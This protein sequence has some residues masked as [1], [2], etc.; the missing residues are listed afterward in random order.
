[1]SLKNVKSLYNEV[2][3]IENIQKRQRLTEVEKF[4]LLMLY[5]ELILSHRTFSIEKKLNERLWKSVFYSN[6]ELEKKSQDSNKLMP[7]IK[8]AK[9]FYSVQISQFL[10]EFNNLVVDYYDFQKFDIIEYGLKKYL[11]LIKKDYLYT[12]KDEEILENDL[13]EILNLTT[14]SQLCL[15]DSARYEALNLKTDIDD[16]FNEAIQ[17]YKQS[18]I[19]KPGNGRAYC[20]LGIIAR[21][22]N[23]TFNVIYFYALSVS[24]IQRN[25]NALSNLKIIYSSV[26]S[27]ARLIQANE[28]SKLDNIF[29]LTICV[30]KTL[31]YTTD[32][33]INDVWDVTE[34]LRLLIQKKIFPKEENNK[35]Y[36]STQ[37]DMMDGDLD[38]KDISNLNKICFLIIFGFVELERKFVDKEF[39]NSKHRIR[40]LQVVALTFLIDIANL[41][42]V[43]INADISD[44]V[45]TN[46]NIFKNLNKFKVFEPLSNVLTWFGLNLPMLILY[47]NL[48]GELGLKHKGLESKLNDLLNNLALALNSIASITD[49]DGSLEFLNTDFELLLTDIYKDYFK[50]LEYESILN[51]FKDVARGSNL[52]ILPKF[53][54][55]GSDLISAGEKIEVFM[56]RVAGFGKT[57]SLENMD[58][59][60]FVFDYE[61]SKFELWTKER[62]RNEG[63]KKLMKVLATQLLTDQVKNLEMQVTSLP[64]SKPILILHHD[65]FIKHLRKVKKWLGFQS[66][67]IVLTLEVIETLDFLKKGVEKVNAQ[68]RETIR[69]LEQKL[70]YKNQSIKT[71]KPNEKYDFDFESNFI[72]STTLQDK[73]IETK[74]NNDCKVPKEFQY[75]ELRSNN[76]SSHIKRTIIN[77]SKLDGSIKKNTQFIKKL[78]TNLNSENLPNLIQD[79]NSLKLEKY[80]E[81]IVIALVEASSKLTKHSEF[82]AL[83]HVASLLHQRFDSFHQPFLDAILSKITPPPK[84]SELKILTPEQR[85]RDERDRLQRQKGHL[86]VLTDMY[87]L[88]VFNDNLPHKYEKKDVMLIGALKDIFEKDLLLLNITIAVTFVKTFSI[89]FFPSTLTEKTTAEEVKL[90][91]GSDESLKSDKQG[92]HLSRYLDTKILNEIQEI[93][94]NYLRNAST[95]LVKEHHRIRQ[96]EKTNNE[97]FIAKGEV[98]EERQ[99][100]YEKALKSFEKV[101]GY[102]QTLAEF[103]GETL[104]ELKIEQEVTRMGV[105][106]GIS[107]DGSREREEKDFKDVLWEDDDTRAFYEDIIDLKTFV[108]SIFFSEKLKSGAK[109]DPNKASE[110]GDDKGVTEELENGTL[111]GVELAE[112]EKDSLPNNP[113][114]VEEEIEVEDIDIENELEEMKDDKKAAPVGVENIFTRIPVSMNRQQIDDIA[115]EFCDYNTKNARKRLVKVLLSSPRQRLDVLPY[116]SRLICT[117][118]IYFPEIGT[119]VLDSLQ[120]EFHFHVKK[121]D[122]H[123][124]E[125]RVKNIR[126]IAELTKFRVTPVHVIFHCIKVLLDSFVSHNI[127]TLCNLLETCGRFLF[128]SAETNLRISNYLDLM[129]KKKNIQNL[130]NRQCLMIENAYYHCN[131]PDQSAIIMKERSPLELYLRKLIYFDLSRRNLEKIVKTLRKL[132]WE[133]DATKNILFKIFSK[134]YKVK[135][136]NLNLMAFLLSELSRYHN[137]FKVLVVDK[138]LEEMRSGLELNLFKFNQRRISII[139]FFGELANYKVFE[140]KLVFDVLYFL[141]RFGHEGGIAKPNSFSPLDAPNDYFRIRLICTLLDTCCNIFESK[142]NKKRI[143]QFLFFFQMYYYT[144]LKPPRDIEYT[145]LETFE[146]LDK[147]MCGSFEESLSLFNTEIEFQKILGDDDKDNDDEEDEKM[148]EKEENEEEVGEDVEEEGEEEEGE[149]EEEEEEEDNEDGDSEQDEIDLEEDLQEKLFELEYQKMMQESLANQYNQKKPAAFDVTIPVKSKFPNLR[150][151]NE[152]ADSIS[153]D[154]NVAFTFLTKKGGKQQAD[155][156][157]QLPS[158]SK[159]VLSTAKKLLEE[160]EE[161][162]E[163]K[164][165]VLNYEQRENATSKSHTN[166]DNPNNESSENLSNTTVSYAQTAKSGRNRGKSGRGGYTVRMSGSTGMFER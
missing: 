159:F 9:N 141:C 62:I 30:V 61:K 76:V 139:K 165:K 14:F 71:Q 22:N 84:S 91:P 146:L 78:K 115:I 99:E 42:L 149:E 125:E 18:L 127:E 63:Q 119:A 21:Y 83:T 56:A 101:H 53:R 70:K 73:E 124:I 98:T 158:D 110:F 36:L 114:T 128:K 38:G 77:Q 122:Q 157:M 148:L 96:V 59:I 44:L 132:N 1:M 166:F 28:S 40:S 89:E 87:L 49:M 95:L 10:T 136:S 13:E 92:L 52:E 120:K 54:M 34:R 81:E 12:C 163:I 147:K 142:K 88:A 86:R 23:D 103:L 43:K 134:I 164:R 69:F 144:K 154:G 20:Q 5:D 35:L 131:P 3:N 82:Q 152:N 140:S 113:I 112:A 79:I 45:T 8:L 108:P 2:Q 41:L 104:P 47:L 102:C 6:F 50:N 68:T 94:K 16:S 90:N 46:S 137:D 107:I 19:L 57:L 130:D 105:G 93:F 4:N 118:N 97:Y 24:N 65:I 155:K 25:S 74:P 27:L 111:N 37:E 85:E 67:I 60:S 15:A 33:Q 121:K 135:F 100:K 143:K 150:V 11:T 55:Y 123:K 26:P 39:S 64:S 75:E 7:A 156:I 129:M 126:Y 80:L 138:L 145:V 51:A 17:C 160:K 66:C 32:D 48:E 151:N 161:K 31:I 162:L 117:L 153:D 116:Y 58:K 29:F 133:D 106:I 109:H 72:K